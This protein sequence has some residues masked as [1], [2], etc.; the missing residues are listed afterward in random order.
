M[1]DQGTVSYQQ[2]AVLLWICCPS[3]TLM[4]VNKLLLPM[5]KFCMTPCCNLEQ[6]TVTT[7][8]IR[9]V[10]CMQ[11]PL[12]RPG[13]QMCAYAGA[14]YVPPAAPAPD[15]HSNAQD[16]HVQ[17][18]ESSSPTDETTPEPCEVYQVGLYLMKKALCRVCYT[19]L[20]ML[21]I[22][23][24]SKPAAVHTQMPTIK[25]NRHLAH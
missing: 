8:G 5:S 17:A 23:K 13:G 3:H 16:R 7:T 22:L 10:T 2:S 25:N 18:N 20:L 4:L 9:L 11:L 12:T 24:A 14:L 19:S 1:H 15:L 6:M 21:D